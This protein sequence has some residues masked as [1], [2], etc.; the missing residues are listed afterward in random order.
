MSSHLCQNRKGGPAAKQ[1]CFDAAVPWCTLPA[2]GLG[3]FH[4]EVPP[5]IV[6]VQLKPVACAEGGKHA[7]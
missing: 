4:A 5:S 1:E 2:K 7:A 6:P 3:P